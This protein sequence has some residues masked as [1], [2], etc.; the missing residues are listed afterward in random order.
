MRPFGCPVT[1]LNTLDPLAKFDG[2]ANE[3]FL[4]GYSV[5]S[6]AF[7]VFNSRTRIV[8]ETLHINFLE[9][10]PNIVGNGPTWLSDIDTLTQSI[11]YQPVV[12]GN[13]T[14]YN[15]GIQG[16]FD[17]GKVGKESVSTQQ[18]VLLP[19][20]STGSKDSQNTDV[21][22][23]FDVKKNES[24]VHVFPCSSDKLKKYDEKAKR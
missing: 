5:S 19:F 3:G 4:V 16:N 14:N 7:R 23:T 8:Q 12:A 18:Y 11:N 6:K 20:W 2:K 1:I 17:E 21:D 22:A 24:E 13:Q 10:Q 9:N 15:A